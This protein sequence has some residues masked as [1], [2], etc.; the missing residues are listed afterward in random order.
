MPADLGGLM[1]T[2]DLPIP[3]DLRGLP[4]GSLYDGRPGILGFP[5]EYSLG[6]FLIGKGNTG[7]GTFQVTTEKYMV[8]TEVV[9]A[10]TDFPAGRGSEGCAT[11]NATLGLWVLG[12]NGSDNNWLDKYFWYSDVTV[13]STLVFTVT[14]RYPASASN[15]SVAIVA[16]GLS[17][18]TTDKYIYAS[19]TIGSGT[20]LPTGA[21]NFLAIATGNPF[22]GL[23]VGGYNGGAGSNSTRKYTY[24]GDVTAA[25][26]NAMD[27]HYFCAGAGCPTYGL[28]VGI[29]G[30]VGVTTK[31]TWNSDVVT[32]GTSLVNVY[33]G[34]AGAGS[35]RYALFNRST[36]DSGA[37][38]KYNFVNEVISTGTSF[39][40]TRQA[41]AMVATV[42]NNV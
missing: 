20:S 22:Y 31:Y 11:G 15:A 42:P 7:V 23:F 33:S 3:S 39:S 34:P 24:A 37:S 2:L 14:G 26:T 32:A 36:L 8:E 12:Y 6:Y 27:S 16:A 35:K 30:A 13:A 10:G 38:S 17:T 25:G 21:V 4:Q 1:R 5:K 18:Y 28:F 29:P 40:T 9:S 19:D 41:G